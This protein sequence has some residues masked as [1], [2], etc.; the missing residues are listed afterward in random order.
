MQ[1]KA[2]LHL[3]TTY[4]VAASTISACA[5]HTPLPLQATLK[6]QQELSASPFEQKTSNWAQFVE[7]PNPTEKQVTWYL[8]YDTRLS[9]TK[10]ASTRQGRLLIQPYNQNTKNVENTSSIIEITIN[11]YERHYFFGIIRVYNQPYAQ[12]HAIEQSNAEKNLH[13]AN[14]YNPIDTGIINFYCKD[15]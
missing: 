3:I 10:N 11:C 2:P 12:G 13:F 15:Q 8:D 7:L 14:S 6:T 4:L 1:L 9:H 5:T